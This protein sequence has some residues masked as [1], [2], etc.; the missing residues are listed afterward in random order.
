MGPTRWDG[1]KYQSHPM[2]WDDNFFLRM[3]WDGTIF[4]SHP[5]PFGALVV[6]LFGNQNHSVKLKLS[7]KTTL[8][9]TSVYTKF[10]VEIGEW[11]FLLSLRGTTVVNYLST[12]KI[13]YLNN[14]RVWGQTLLGLLSTLWALPIDKRWAQTE[15]ITWGGSLVS[16]K[17]LNP[18]KIFS[19]L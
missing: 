19:F 14:N 15:G 17:G 3:G 13:Q 18:R 9:G 2:G 12:L 5:I 1:T 16:D 8:T 11:V 4:S 7:Q 10:Q 6:T